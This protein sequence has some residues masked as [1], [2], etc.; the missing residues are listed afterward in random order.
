MVNNPDARVWLGSEVP[1]RQ[2]GIKVHGCPFGHDEDKNLEMRD[3]LEAGDTEA[4]SLLGPLTAKGADHT[5]AMCRHEILDEE[6]RSRS[7]PGEG[8]FAPY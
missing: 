6:F 7:A 4:I 8:R 5:R 2:Q 3:A 1:T